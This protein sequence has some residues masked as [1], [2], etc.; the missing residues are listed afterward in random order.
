MSWS[1]VS[2]FSFC[3]DNC[4]EGFEFHN[5]ANLIANTILCNCFY[6]INVLTFWALP[7]VKKH[8]NVLLSCEPDIK[9]SDIIF[10]KK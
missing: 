5:Q 10:I 1:K 6:V 2:I 7:M 3:S 8:Y 9:L 4:L